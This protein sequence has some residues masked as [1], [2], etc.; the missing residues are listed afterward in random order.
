MKVVPLP[1][2]GV[3]FTTMWWGCYHI[4]VESLPLCGVTF[5]SL[6]TMVN[7]QR[8]LQC[9][10][11]LLWGRNHAG[12]CSEDPSRPSR[13]RRRGVRTSV[14]GRLR[15]SERRTMLASVFPSVSRLDRRSRPSAFFS[16]K[17]RKTV[18]PTTIRLFSYI[19][20]TLNYFNLVLPFHRDLDFFNTFV[21]L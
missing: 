18:T 9:S 15:L 8:L 5:T 19:E 4:E 3:T 20:L 21:T 11:S 16:I 2:C 13:L 10:D 14:E 7:F 1:L 17:A 12:G 6:N